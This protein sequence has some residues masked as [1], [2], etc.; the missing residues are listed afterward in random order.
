M[1]V[2]RMIR[3]LQATAVEVGGARLFIDLRVASSHFFLLTNEWPE[4]QERRLIRSIVRRGQ[5]G[6]DVGAHW[7]IYTVLLSELVGQGGRV[8]AFEPSPVV[9]PS[10]FRTVAGLPNT[11]L[12]PLALSETPGRAT[13]FVPADASMASLANWTHSSEA[14]R[15]RCDVDVQSLDI[16]AAEGRVPPADF[17]KCDVEGAEALVFRGARAI[18]DRRL[19]PVILFEFNPRASVALGLPVHEAFDTL[20]GLGAP[21]YRFYAI[22]SKLGPYPVEGRPSTFTNVLAVPRAR[23]AVF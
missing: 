11:T 3:G 16:L 17:I 15:K 18:L 8:F 2:A 20:E 14:A 7:G 22:D 10:L 5:V 9:L 4:S 12:L 1:A 6:L 21:G 23:T 13:F 19:A